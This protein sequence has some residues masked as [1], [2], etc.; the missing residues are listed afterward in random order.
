MNL[1]IARWILTLPLVFASHSSFAQLRLI[2]H[3]DNSVSSATIEEVSKVYLGKAR[4][5][6]G[7]DTLLVLDVDPSSASRSGYLEKVV[8]KK[9]TELKQYWS[10][11]VFTGKGVPPKLV[12]ND[13]AVVKMV[14]DNKNAIG[15][16]NLPVGPEVKI[17]L[18]LN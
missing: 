6:P 14:S 1:K 13:E 5:L 15:I 18:E 9:E 16:V 4:N 10:R 11:I 17:V 8:Q 2:V 7:G 3:K 12:G